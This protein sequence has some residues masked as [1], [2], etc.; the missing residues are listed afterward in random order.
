MKKLTILPFLL[1]VLMMLV[2]CR[3]SAAPTSTVPTEIS[4]DT[5][6]TPTPS[7]T[8]IP[9]ETAMSKTGI[10]ID[11]FEADSTSWQ[12]GK[13]PNYPGSGALSVNL[14]DQYA[15]Q[16]TQSLQLNFESGESAATFLLEGQFN[17]NKGQYLAFDLIDPDQTV[18]TVALSLST[19]EDW[20]WH[21]SPD[22]IPPT[23]AT[24][25]NFDLDAKTFK[26][27]ATDW[28]AT[29][30]LTD[31]GDVRRIAILLTTNKAGS[32]YI[33]NLRLLPSDSLVSLP[34]TAPALTSVPTPTPGPCPNKAELPASDAP[35]TILLPTD[36]N[37]TRGNLLEFDLQTTFQVENPYDPAQID[38]VVHYTTPDG[39]QWT[40][41]A[42][43]MQEFDPA[44]RMACGQ[45]GWKARL[46]PTQSGTWTAQAEIINA[47]I[48]SEAITFDVS[49][50]DTEP[51]SI[52]RLHPADPR[53]LATDQGETFF[54]IG[55]NIGWWQDDPI[56][57]YTRWLDSFSENGGNL[58]RVWMASWS[59]G[60]EWN[61]TG[62]GNYDRRQDRAWFLDQLFQIA[63]ERGVYIDLVILNHGA[64]ST[65]TNPE[66]DDNPYNTDNGGMC[67]SPASFATD[68]EAK[69]I[70]KKRVRYITARWG[71]A[72]NLLAWEWWNEYNWTPITDENMAPWTQEMTAYLQQYDPYDHLVST[73]TAGG[74]HPI[75]FNLPEID[76]LQHHAYTSLDPLMEYPTT[77]DWY[78]L[79]I[80]PLKPVVFG[81]FGYNAG[82]ENIDSFDKTGIHLHNGLWTATF[83]QFAST[84][85]YWWWEHFIEPRALWWQFSSISNFIAG[86]DLAQYVPLGPGKIRLSD[87]TN[88]KL[89]AIYNP[90]GMLAWIRHAQYEAYSAQVDQDNKM[91]YENV[92]LEEW[93]YDLDPITGLTL[94][95]SALPDGEYT[96]E[97]YD[98]QTSQWLS[99]ETITITEGTV[100]IAIPEFKFDLAIRI[101]ALP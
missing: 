52:I 8:P 32:V 28:Q 71:Y 69:E 60:I 7:V 13:P 27:A 93:E 31:R 19:G 45:P 96:L 39:S 30:H 91:R 73:S 20:Y 42:F 35:L 98:P 92:P 83:S 21:A 44:I 99:T 64:F 6:D 22:V 75:V 18:Q 49:A 81:E 80:D 66:W 33:D 51:L 97:W 3:E 25:I 79:A 74:I 1:I 58:I 70:F 65:S 43:W 77:Y 11:D 26:I 24:Q 87:Q 68:P 56:N 14:S 94:T 67:D 76:F 37:P 10:T 86:E 90:Q 84:A 95:T 48:R 55:L 88:V 16:G 15:I 46:T 34:P 47:D 17:L 2:A 41:P 4:I 63:A 61:D 5:S 100:T 82:I 59:F 85:M 54:P 72:T 101:K 23:D 36:I 38:L 50:S 78:E 53:Y 40:I 9:S 62:L 57:D 12:A 89:A 29:A